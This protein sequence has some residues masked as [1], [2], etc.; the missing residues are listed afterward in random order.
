MNN[1][2]NVYKVVMPVLNLGDNVV[3]KEWVDNNSYNWSVVSLRDGAQVL[4][5]ATRYREEVY[6]PYP[7]QCEPVKKFRARNRVT[8][9][10]VGG[11]KIYENVFSAECDAANRDKVNVE[12]PQ[13][14]NEIIAKVESIYQARSNNQ[15]Q[16]LG[17]HLLQERVRGMGK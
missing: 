6:C 9:R 1:I 14:V 12:F 13:Q 16:K 5:I 3:F 7:L 17:L 2:D 11:F 8:M 15:E 4:H 10:T